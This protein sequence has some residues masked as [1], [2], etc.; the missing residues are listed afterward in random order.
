M[1]Q[2]TKES[3]AFLAFS[4][5]AASI[6]DNQDNLS[7]TGLMYS[8]IIQQLIPEKSDLLHNRRAKSWRVLPATSTPVNLSFPTLLIPSGSMQLPPRED[9][10]RD[11][12]LDYPLLSATTRPIDN[13]LGDSPK[14]VLLW[15]LDRLISREILDFQSLEARIV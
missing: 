7:L 2:Q 9:E 4:A 3:T 14:T 12:L 11:Q 15:P 5:R 6:S 8:N 1:L 10:H 13:R